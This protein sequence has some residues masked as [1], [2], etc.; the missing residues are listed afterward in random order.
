MSEKKFPALDAFRIPAA[1][2]VIAIHTSPLASV[3]DLGDFWF[4]RV[5]ARVAVPFFFMMTGRF[6]GQTPGVSGSGRCCSMR[7][8]HC[9]ICL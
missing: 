8:L 9:C 7:V 1:V 2:L 4:T 6:L 3:S 5:L